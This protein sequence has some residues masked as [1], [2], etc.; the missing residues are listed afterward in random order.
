[1]FIFRAGNL[2]LRHLGEIT[3]MLINFWD[4]KAMCEKSGGLD[5]A[6]KITLKSTSVWKQ[7]K[8]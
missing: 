1:M 3:L 8:T 2:A 4:V 5:S 6:G 7:L